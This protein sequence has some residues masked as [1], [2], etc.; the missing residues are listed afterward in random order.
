[1][2]L[3]TT[4]YYTL[5]TPHHNTLITPH[6]LG[7]QGLELK[8]LLCSPS[9]MRNQTAVFLIGCSDDVTAILQS[10]IPKGRDKMSICKFTSRLGLF[11]T[12]DYILFDLNLPGN[13]NVLKV[14]PVADIL[15][16]SGSNLTDGSAMISADL[17]RELSTARPDLFRENPMASFQFRMKGCKGERLSD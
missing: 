10:L 11:C 14:A 5:I 1:M 13:R 3:I 8:L 17:M 2:H 6:R 15:T 16:V 4:C 7:L 9:Q 12:A